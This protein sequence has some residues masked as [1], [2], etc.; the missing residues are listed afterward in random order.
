MKI[1][2]NSNGIEVSYLIMFLKN[3]PFPSYSILPENPIENIS[4]LKDGSVVKYGFMKQKDGITTF[5]IKSSFAYNP[6]NATREFNV[7]SIKY[8]SYTH[9]FLG[10]YLRYFRDTTGINLMP[11]YNCYANEKLSIEST[12]FDYYIVPVKVNQIYTIG[13]NVRTSFNIFIEKTGS[14]ATTLEYIKADDKKKALDK[15]LKEHKI[16]CIPGANKN[17]P[18]TIKTP[19]TIIIDDKAY[20]PSN[21]T[22]DAIIEVPKTANTSITVLEGNYELGASQ[23][24]YDYKYFTD[25]DKF[26][27]SA[28]N[29]P[30]RF[31]LLD[32]TDNKSHPMADRLVEYLVGSVIT[33]VDEVQYD[34]ARL[35]ELTYKNDTFIGNYDIFGDELRERLFSKANNNKNQYGQCYADALIDELYYGDKDIIS[36]LVEVNRKNA[37]TK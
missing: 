27:I 16:I 2:Y 19:E 32:I 37:A 1:E 30:S 24:L 20:T 26:D 7:K 34:V 14:F 28:N 17:E 13:I 25:F 23:G 8:T 15:L 12:D 35:Q 36:M 31:S 18:F 10:D 6:L 3:H 11:L 21:L 29:L 33:P 22:F 5:G 4:Y 9:K